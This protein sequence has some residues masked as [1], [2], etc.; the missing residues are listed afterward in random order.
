MEQYIEI[1]LLPDPDFTASVLMNA[2]FA[3]LHRALLEVSHGEIGVSFPKA[4][5]TLED[6]IRLHGSVSALQRLM[7]I[8]WLKGLTDY[9]NISA[10]T[11]VPDNCQ[12]RV[13]NRV[14]A[15]SSAVRLYRRSVKKGW[16]TV[17]DA[18]KKITGIKE[19]HIKQ[20]FVQL[21]SHSSGQTFRLF[22]Q[23][24]KLLGSPQAGK[25]SD[26]GLSGEATI[27]WF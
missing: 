13:V 11:P 9:I 23:Q 24:G 25:F 12:Y 20:P 1:R 6:I 21:K 14:Q 2:L 10:I 3:K 4:Q 18:E 27:P 17:E 8:T 19:Q 26:Y 5:K 15:K 16:L 7:E 22:I